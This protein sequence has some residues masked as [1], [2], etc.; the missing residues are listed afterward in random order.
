MLKRHKA[1]LDVVLF[2]CHSLSLSSTAFPY[3]E[4]TTVFDWAIVLPSSPSMVCSLSL[5]GPNM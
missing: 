2:C 1:C 4:Y 5:S 3:R